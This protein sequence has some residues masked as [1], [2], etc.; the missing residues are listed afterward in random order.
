MSN[1]LIV[2]EAPKDEATVGAEDCAFASLL[3]T[4]EDCVGAAGTLKK[5][6]EAKLRA[7]LARAAEIGITDLQAEAL[8]NALRDATGIGKKAIK[9]AWTVFKEKADAEKAAEAEKERLKEAAAWAARAQAQRDEERARLWASCGRFAENPSLLAGMAAVAHA[10]GLVGEEAAVRGVYLTYVSRLLAGSAIRL[11]RLG[12]TASGK[13]IP[14]E[15][16][17]PLMPEGGVEQFS[18]SSPK[19]LAYFGRDDPDALKHKVIYIPE[20]VILAN[21][22][23]GVEN[24]FTAMLRTLISEGRLVYRTVV[25]DRDGNRDTETIVKNGPIAAIFTTA[26]D[27]DVEMKT[28]ALVQETDESGAQTAAIV[29]SVLSQRK[30]ADNFQPWID[31]QLWLELDMPYRVELPFRE[32]ISEAFDPWRPGFLEEAAIRMR[33][34]VSSFVVAIEASAVL[35]KAQREGAEDGAVIATLDDYQHAYEAFGEGLATVHGKADAKVIAVVKIIEEMIKENEEND[36]APDSAKVTLRMLAKKLRVG[37]P[38]TAGAR[39]NAA[40]DYGAI[41]RTDMSGRGGARYFRVAMKSEEIE[42]EP[43][44]GVFPPPEVVRKL[45]SGPVISEDSGQIGQMD[46]TAGGKRRI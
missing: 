17:L 44:L 1:D 13:N 18:G 11:L 5:G 19:T 25:I 30:R 21:K 27:I 24:E 22:Q 7:I 20:A 26:R 37:S 41:E 12:S 31:L 2:T 9:K 33:R 38:T 42:A 40:L 35:H 32:A 4:Y 10:R 14:I 15:L 6:D 43:G 23:Q 45:F 34:D 3:M 39:L 46:R 28:R 29:H 8:I 16:T 36:L